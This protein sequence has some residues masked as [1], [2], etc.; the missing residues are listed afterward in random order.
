MMLFPV[1]STFTTIAS[2]SLRLSTRGFTGQFVGKNRGEDKPSATS[3]K[4]YR[5]CFTR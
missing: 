5:I 4:L 3:G 1:S 2:S